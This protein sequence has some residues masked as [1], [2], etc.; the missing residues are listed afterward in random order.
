MKNLE[1]LASLIT[2]SRARHVHACRKYIIALTPAGRPEAPQK[3]REFEKIKK[4]ALG[5]RVGIEKKAGDLVRRAHE[6]EEFEK[7]TGIEYDVMGPTLA[8][9]GDCGKTFQYVN[10]HD[11]GKVTLLETRR[12]S[13]L[14]CG[15]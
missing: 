7:R 9:C 8:I 3:L 1:I 14:R 6:I 13:Y 2:I 10:D 12:T 4:E 15:A 5:E 11:H